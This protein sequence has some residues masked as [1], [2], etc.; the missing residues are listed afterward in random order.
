M[1]VKSIDSTISYS[2]EPTMKHET[3][4]TLDEFQ[5]APECYY[6]RKIVNI[7]L[8]MI[9]VGGSFFIVFL[10]IYLVYILLK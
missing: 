10:L 7:F 6:L 2:W 5:D 8:L 3:I 4:L 9:M 1:S